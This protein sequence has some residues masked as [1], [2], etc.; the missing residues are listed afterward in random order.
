MKILRD[1]QREMD[2]L[3]FR[4]E[5]SWVW[6]P[7]KLFYNDAAHLDIHGSTMWCLTKEHAERIEW[8]SM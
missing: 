6:K 2:K 1:H 5:T 7:T 8:R 3:R 4:Q